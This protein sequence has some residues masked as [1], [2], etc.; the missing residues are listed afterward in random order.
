MGLFASAAAD[1]ASDY[2][3]LRHAIEMLANDNMELRQRLKAAETRI[4]A[5]E[6][7]QQLLQCA[8]MRS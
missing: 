7:V 4:A 3:E 1:S 6:P 2:S 5:L 8:S